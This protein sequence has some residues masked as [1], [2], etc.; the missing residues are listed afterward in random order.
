MNSARTAA[1][2]TGLAA[3]VLPVVSAT[4]ASA[5]TTSVR[6]SVTMYSD[7][8]DFIGQGAAQLFDS[9]NAAVRVNGDRSGLTVAVDGGTSGTTFTFQIAPAVGASLS[10]GVFDRAERSASAGRPGLDVY[11]DGRGCN[12]VAGSYEVRDVAF[13]AGGAVSR[14]HLLYEQHCEGWPAAL[15]GEV[16]YREPAAAGL[17]AESSSV[18]WP[19]TYP[20]VAATVVPVTVR[21]VGRSARIAS[22]SVTGADAAAFPVRID[23]CSGT[24]LPAGG[25]CQVFLRAAPTGGGPRPASLVLV[26]GAGRRTAVQLDASARTGATGL[27]LKGDPGDSI[28]GGASYAYSPATARFQVAGSRQRVS[29]VVDAGT[30][31]FSVDMVPSQ[32][33]VLAPGTYG[34]AERYPFNG[35][36]PGLNVDGNGDWR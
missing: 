31:R 15:F 36:A 26:D 29:A 30:S 3:L 6:S 32:G 13:A 21:S 5:A 16:R 25:S 35:S 11:G 7:P 9:N 19:T 27:S 10:P 22:A 14:L 18:T 28:T 17:V 4:P 20:G 23:G 33:D 2:L 1:L 8:G 24:T 34:G 12:T